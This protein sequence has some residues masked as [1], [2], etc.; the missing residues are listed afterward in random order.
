MKNTSAALA[1]ALSLVAGSGAAFADCKERVR[2]LREEINDE[3]GNYTLA[4]RTAAK[5]H[6]AAAELTLM[7]PLKCRQSLREARRA[8]REG[9]K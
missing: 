5:R 7:Q 2:E 9:E 3:R 6:L 8:L 4:A 1:I